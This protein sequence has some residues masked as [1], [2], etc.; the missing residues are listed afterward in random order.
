[1]SDSI[2]GLV[3]K[4]VDGDTFVANVTWASPNNQFRY[5]SQETIR[6]ANIDASELGTTLGLTQKQ[7]LERL[8]DGKTV[9]L[10]VRSRDEYHRLVCDVRLA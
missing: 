6:I 8:I 4:V 7:R 2:K 9:N 1:M 3:I 5:N 10:T